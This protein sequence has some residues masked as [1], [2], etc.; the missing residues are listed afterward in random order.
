MFLM[1]H[2]RPHPETVETQ[3]PPPQKKEEILDHTP[4]Q[5]E[6][7]ATKFCMVIKLEESKIFTGSTTPT[8]LAKKFCDTNGDN[9]QCRTVN[10]SNNLRTLRT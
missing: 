4:T 6:Q 7:I 9:L 1:G 3:R 5:Q 2:L 10:A 8:T